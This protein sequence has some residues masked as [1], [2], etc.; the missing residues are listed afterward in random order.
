MILQRPRADVGRRRGA[1]VIVVLSTLLLLVMTGASACGIR[2][3]SAASLEPV[4][5]EPLEAFHPPFQTFVRSGDTIESVSRRLAGA[6]WVRWR[7]ALSAEIDPKKLFPGTEFR[8]RSLPSGTL[9]TVEVIFDRRNEVHLTAAPD[10]ISITR[11]ERPITSEVV[12]LEG[13]VVSSLFGA[14]DTAG[15]NPDLAVRVAQIYQWDIDFFRDLRQNDTFVVVAERQQIEGEFYAW[16]TIYATRFVNRDRVLNAM[17]YPDNDGRLGYFDLEGHPL[18]KQFLKSPLKFSRVTSNFSMNRF[19]PVLKRRMPHYG[20]DYGAPTGTPVY[21]TADGTVA[22]AGRKGGGGNMVT[23]RH[24]NG[25]ET[26]Y[27]HLSRFGKGMRRGVRVTQGQVIGY[28]GSTGLASGP[29]LDYRVQLNGRWINPLSISSPP[30]KP[31]VEKRLQRFLAH[32]LAVLSLIDGK[33]PPV[34]A[35]C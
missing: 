13:V 1:C 15:G 4:T 31:L 19:H 23:I 10:G 3:S 18:R 9:E 5:V 17:V 6:D 12:R 20:V 11:V 7:D 33:S 8:G 29:H 28:V 16:G 32:A 21:V 14:M 30:V 25:Y 2:P 26:N 35:R 22:F 34:G 27:L 24:T